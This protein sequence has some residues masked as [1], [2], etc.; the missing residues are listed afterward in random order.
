LMWLSYSHFFLRNDE[1]AKGGVKPAKGFMGLSPF[2]STVVRVEFTDFIFA[3]DSILAAVA[4]SSKTWVV[5]TGGIL[6]IIAMRL[7]VGQLLSL[8]QR[9]P[10]VVDGAFVIIAWVATRL[11]VEYAHQTGWITWGISEPVSLGVIVLIFIG[12]AWYAKRAGPRAVDSSAADV[13]EG[14]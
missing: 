5:I 14:R 12:A 2:W 10:A 7:V 8:V 4:M 11:L 6:G 13:L 9:Y 1:A 3:I